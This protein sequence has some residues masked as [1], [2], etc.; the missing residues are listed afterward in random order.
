MIF[1]AVKCPSTENPIRHNGDSEWGTTTVLR[2]SDLKYIKK[3][4][5]LWMGLLKAGVEL[6]SS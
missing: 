3:E 5:W 4:E 6:G 2:K 1:I